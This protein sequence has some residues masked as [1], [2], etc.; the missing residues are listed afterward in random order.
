MNK[1]ER[2]RKLNESCAWTIKSTEY[3]YSHDY[4]SY[5]ELIEA[6]RTAKN[7]WKKLEDVNSTET[8]S[9]LFAAV[10]KTANEILASVNEDISRTI[11]NTIKELNAK[12]I[13]NVTTNSIQ[14]SSQNAIVIVFSVEA[15]FY[16]CVFQ[17]TLDYGYREL[18]LKGDSAGFQRI[19]KLATGQV[20]PSEFLNSNNAEQI[21]ALVQFL[22]VEMRGQAFPGQNQLIKAKLSDFSN[23]IKAKSNRLEDLRSEIES[24]VDETNS[25]LETTLAERNDEYNELKD[26]VEVWHGKKEDSLSALEDTYNQKLQLEAPVQFWEK[27]ATEKKKS[28]RIWLG[29]TSAVSVLLVGIVA[30]LFN[31]VYTQPAGVAGQLIPLSFIVIALI[32]LLIYAVKTLVKITMT[33]RHLST[34]F[35]QKA[36]FTH[37][38]LSLLQKGGIDTKDE[39]RL[40]IYNAIFS[41]VDT[42]L[43]KTTN[44]SDMGIS[45]LLKAITKP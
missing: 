39:E 27:R 25:K 28:F 21:S 37:F 23:E 29:A 22:G 6:L 30:A 44:D 15:A 10:E 42:G 12:S 40:L 1:I 5:E 8:F 9:G 2:V 41:H 3:A 33:E 19:T 11:Q 14:R 31:L 4:E 34:E 18:Y 16:D 17:N 36:M 35:E 20:R 26:S 45:E 13:V 43:V 24:F 38:Y 32:A 7:H